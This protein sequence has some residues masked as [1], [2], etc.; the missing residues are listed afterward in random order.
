LEALISRKGAHSLASRALQQVRSI[1]WACKTIVGLPLYVLWADGAKLV[2]LA[3][4]AVAVC[5]AG[6]SIY[7]VYRD[8]VSRP[9]R[10]KSIQVQQ[11]QMRLVTLF[12]VE[13]ARLVSETAFFYV[14]QLTDLKNGLK[15]LGFRSCCAIMVLV[16]RFCFPLVLS[17]EGFAMNFV[18]IFCGW[19]GF[20]VI[21][22]INLEREK[23]N[24]AQKT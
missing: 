3:F 18:F 9:S 21:V 12:T 8:K 20:A 19:I 13:C 10:I 5:C 17:A 1:V 14:A 7:L 15:M 2:G 22:A 6:L 23:D 11:N 24:V 4:A 16:L